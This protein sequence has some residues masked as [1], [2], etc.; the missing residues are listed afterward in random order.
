M[1]RFLLHA[2]LLCAMFLVQITGALPLYAEPHC[3]ETQ[4]N[5]T[6]QVSH[7]P[8]HNNVASAPC[9]ENGQCDDCYHCHASF[10]YILPSSQPWHSSPQQKD[11]LDYHLSAALTLITTKDHPPRMLVS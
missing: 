1:K 5:Q 4:Q 10:A 7:L 9:C 6:A 3:V 8:C 11:A 2:G